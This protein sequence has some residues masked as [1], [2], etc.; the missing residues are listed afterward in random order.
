MDALVSHLVI[1]VRFLG[2]YPLERWIIWRLCS[3][4]HRFPYKC[5]QFHTSHGHQHGGNLIC[6]SLWRQLKTK[7]KSTTLGSQL[8]ALLL[9]EKRSMFWCKSNRHAWT[10][11][12]IVLIVFLFH[13]IVEILRTENQSFPVRHAEYISVTNILKYLKF[14]VF[15]TSSILLL[16][17]PSS[18]V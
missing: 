12:Y 14:I 8:L 6:I 5:L 9:I 16:R 13:F 7:N 17:Y 15:I 11:K 4:A 1:L 18:I 3:W 2:K 10:N